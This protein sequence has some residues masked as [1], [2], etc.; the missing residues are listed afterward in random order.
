MKIKNHPLI[1]RAKEH[2]AEHKPILM[3]LIG[4]IVLL[5]SKI[6]LCNDNNPLPMGGTDHTSKFTA[7]GDLLLTIDGLVFKVGARLLAGVCIL[8]GGWNIKEQ[9]FATAIICVIAAIVIATVP[10]W[11]HNIFAFAGGGIFAK[12]TGS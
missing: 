5:L 8:A 2:F 12:S 1:K 10:M 9:R 11:I 4:M 6:T 7:A 3:F